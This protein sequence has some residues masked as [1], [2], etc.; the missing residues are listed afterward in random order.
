MPRNR[1]HIPRDQRQAELLS[2]A[3]KV[4]IEEGYVGTTI[5]RISEAAGVAR[6][7]VYWYYKSKDDVFAAVMSEMLEN[8]IARL[9]SR[10]V[11]PDA[12][13]RLTTGLKEMFPFRSLH[14]EMHERIPYS[15]AVREAHDVFL[16]WM[17]EQVHEVAEE[18]SATVDKELL[19]DV[20]VAI[21]EGSHIPPAG[22]PAHEML[23]HVL[24]SMISHRAIS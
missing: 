22:R 9:N 7:N 24:T 2:A 13:T 15:E 21:F 19:A 20:I 12:Y 14:R 16:N 11:A 10:P 4:F 23:P 8:E 18:S 1:R 17:R 6:A 5:T 3:T